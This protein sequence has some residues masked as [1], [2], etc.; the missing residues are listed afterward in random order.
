MQT[1]TSFG[2][3][4]S[5]AGAIS[6]VIAFTSVA[7][8]CIF[9]RELWSK[10]QSLAELI[11]SKE[12]VFIGTVTSIEKGEFNRETG[13]SP[14][15]AVFKVEKMIKGDPAE[16]IKIPAASHTCAFEFRTGDR[17]L[18]ADK[19]PPRPPLLYDVSTNITWP[20]GNFRTPSGLDPYE[21]R[22]AYPEFVK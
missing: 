7:N 12:L 20:L 13:R 18:I 6:L 2:R 1:L 15:Y 3:I 5:I 11:A 14:F 16:W 9:P 19:L 10:P 21:L 4:Q 8:G 22:D 17:W